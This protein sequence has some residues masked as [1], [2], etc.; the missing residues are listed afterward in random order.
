VRAFLAAV[1]R[2]PARTI[3]ARSASQD[4]FEGGSGQPK[5]RANSKQ[6]RALALLCGPH[7]Q[8]TSE[9]GILCLKSRARLCT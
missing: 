9:R 1:V 2:K 5:G 3:K 4:P 8:L 7:N 6:A